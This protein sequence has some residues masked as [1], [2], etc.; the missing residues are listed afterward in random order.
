VV[1]NLRPH[2]ARIV[3]A[4]VAANSDKIETCRLTPQHRHRTSA[5]ARDGGRISSPRIPAS[6]AGRCD[7]ASLGDGPRAGEV[8]HRIV[9]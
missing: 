9:F 8:C 6:A 5:Q 4:W 3:T 7:G 1:D 2:R